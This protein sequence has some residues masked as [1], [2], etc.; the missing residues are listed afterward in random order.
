MTG[1]S[2]WDSDENKVSTCQLAS[3]VVP[4]ARAT[5]WPASPLMDDLSAFVCQPPLFVNPLF[6]NPLFVNPLCLS[7]HSVCCLSTPF[8]CQPPLLVNPLCHLRLVELLA[9]ESAVREKTKSGMQICTLHDDVL[10]R[11]ECTSR[12]LSQNLEEVPAEQVA[13]GTR[14]GGYPQ[15]AKRSRECR[16]ESVLLNLA[17]AGVIE[18]VSPNKCSKVESA[19]VSIDC[20]I[21]S[22]VTD[23]RHMYLAIVKNMLADT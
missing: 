18:S 9:G 2:G 3:G 15:Y 1:S 20:A 11:Q 5:W 4:L 19:F 17:S 22:A 6:V 10:S 13:E 23:R 8:V 12:T 16:D 14:Y 21:M 7:T